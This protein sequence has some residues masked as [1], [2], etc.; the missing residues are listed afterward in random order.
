MIHTYV[1]KENSSDRDFKVIC[2]K[3][4]K[5]C[6]GYALAERESYEGRIESVIWKKGRMSIF[7][8][9]EKDHGAV[10]VCSDEPLPS[11]GKLSKLWKKGGYIIIRKIGQLRSVFLPLLL[12]VASLIGFLIKIKADNLLEILFALPI[13]VYYALNDFLLNGVYLGWAWLIPI[14]ALLT[15]AA[16]RQEK[17][18]NNK[19]SYINGGAFKKLLGKIWETVRSEADFLIMLAAGALPAAGAL[20]A[21]S[22]FS[23]FTRI[24]EEVK[25]FSQNPLYAPLALY[26][27]ALPY[28]IINKKILK[29]IEKRR[30][31]PLTKTAVIM[32]ILSAAA[33]LAVIAGCSDLTAAKS[34][35]LYN[36][37]QALIF[38]A[39]RLNAEARQ[40][41]IS[42]KYGSELEAIARYTLEKQYLDWSHCPDERLEDVWEQVFLSGAADYK[43]SIEGDS[44]IFTVSGCDYEVTPGKEDIE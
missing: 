36:S 18:V 4:E 34:A 22:K 39:E 44:V 20:Y 7:A 1:F 30:K 33:A 27:L 24:W 10:T 42:L 5:E 13:T 41:L 37:N 3:I 25:I 6:P 31:S 23:I 8:E 32:G 38:K 21:C 12:T 26:I 11:L 15:A 17:P 9:L 2:Q 19:A 35:E 29:G 16:H 28:I 14:G 43:V 40:E